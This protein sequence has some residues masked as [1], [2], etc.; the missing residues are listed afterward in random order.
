[1]ELVHR[2]EEMI[3]PTV[4]AMGFRVVKVDFTGGRKP[5]LQIMAEEAETGR[6]NVEDCASISRAVSAILDVEDPLAGTYALEV[7]SPGIDRPL[8]RP[9]D[10]GKFVGFEAKIETSRAIDGRKRF[11][12]RLAQANNE[13]V[14]IETKERAY[15]LAYQDI[16]SAKLLLSDDLIAAAQGQRKQ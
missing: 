5:C 10:F 6:M 16:H 12:G 13:E 3:S 8:T 9:E 4:E 1:M 15:D 11:K 14:R 2:I 7:S